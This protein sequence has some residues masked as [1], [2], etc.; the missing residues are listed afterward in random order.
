MSGPPKGYSVP[1]GVAVDKPIA[2]LCQTCS[3]REHW[4]YECKKSAAST[5]ITVKQPVTTGLSKLSKTQMLKL[6]LK[7]DLSTEAPPKTEGEVLNEELKEA[8][9]LEARGARKRERT[10]PEAAQQH[11]SVNTRKEERHALD[12]L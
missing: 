11:D 12:E 8:A 2:K 10:E 7:K 6:G 5:N 3:S 9:R 4:T 1:R